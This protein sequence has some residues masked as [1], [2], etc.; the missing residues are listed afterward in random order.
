MWIID[1][2]YTDAVEQKYDQ[3]YDRGGGG[4]RVRGCE[5]A[6]YLH[7]KRGKIFFTLAGRECSC[8]MLGRRL[9]LAVPMHSSIDKAPLTYPPF[10]RLCSYTSINII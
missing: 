5:A 3:K 10:H 4:A 8:S 2:S 7:V 9:A 6:D 1:C